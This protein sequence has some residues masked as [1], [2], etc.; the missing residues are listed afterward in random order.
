MF[1]AP[2]M[3]V[4]NNG[5]FGWHKINS[6]RARVLMKYLGL[7]RGSIHGSYI[8]AYVSN[9]FILMKR[10]TESFFYALIAYTPSPKLRIWL[11]L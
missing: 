5:Q 1:Q 4:V 8:F 10:C 6:F 7:S 9:C 11:L 2:L 3:F